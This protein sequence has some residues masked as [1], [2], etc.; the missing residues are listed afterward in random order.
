MPN[1]HHYFNCNVDILNEVA[2][3]IVGL[4]DVDFQALQN[5]SILKWDVASQKWKIVY[6]KEA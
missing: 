2:L 1:W 6:S 3:K 4:S 5:G